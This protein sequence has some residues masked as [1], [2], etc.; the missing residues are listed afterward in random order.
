MRR[1]SKA[2]RFRR[3]R[4]LIAL[5]ATVAVV[6]GV[7]LAGL[8]TFL[9]VLV[10][11]SRQI[12]NQLSALAA[13]PR[14][15]AVPAGTF[16]ATVDSEGRRSAS[17][18]APD[19]LP[20]AEQQAGARRAGRDVIEETGVGGREYRT[21]TRVAGGAVV[22]A[23]VALE[24]YESE[25]HRLLAGL[26]FAGLGAA[27]VAAALGA[28]L[29]RSV[30]SVWDDALTRQ[31]A[32]IADASHELRTPLA[33][34]A[35]RADLLQRAVRSGAPQET[36]SSDAA[37]LRE[38]SGGLA[39]IVDDLLQAADL[40]GASDAGELVDLEELVDDV[41]RRNQVLATERGVR[42]GGQLGVVP[43]VRGTPTAL[44]RAVDALVD[45]ALRHASSVVVVTL[46]SDD[47]GVEVL[48]DDDGP[49][50]SAAD[51]ER[52]FTRFARGHGSDR[53][54][55]IGLALVREVVDRHGG[56]VAAVALGRGTRFAIRIPP[57]RVQLKG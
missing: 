40:E 31:R 30:V 41:V 35:L 44:R 49:G 1:P 36:L 16:V 9:L 14:T 28:R 29:G 50:L 4:R 3:A 53:G 17:P 42:L 10:G 57:E 27:L 8:V 48:V 18:G 32:F 2:D 20:Q 24:P 46:R 55:G 19:E 13:A 52:V 45:N 39:D 38:E 15:A 56:T 34:L 43:P 33:R 25:R 54:F 23:G 5:Q 37:L 47:L 21:L 12:D 11:Q 22:Q 7:A 6:A 26:A 51:A